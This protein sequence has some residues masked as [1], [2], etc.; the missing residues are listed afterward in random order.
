[1]RGCGAFAGP[2]A[3]AWLKPVLPRPRISLGIGANIAASRRVPQKTARPVPR[4]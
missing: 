1:M 4:N 2:Q 3:E